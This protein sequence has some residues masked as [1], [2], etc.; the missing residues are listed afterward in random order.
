M[1]LKIKDMKRQTLQVLN[2]SLKA[3]T[4]PEKADVWIKTERV[5]CGTQ[6]RIQLVAWGTFLK[7][8]AQFLV[9]FGLLCALV[10]GNFF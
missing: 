1:P 6:L 10:S 7:I 8:K 2:P 4:A 3:K 9:V 5:S